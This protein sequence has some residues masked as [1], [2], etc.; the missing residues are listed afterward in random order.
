MFETAAISKKKEY[1]EVQQRKRGGSPFLTHIHHHL[2]L[3]LCHFSLTFWLCQGYGFDFNFIPHHSMMLTKPI[4][5][6]GL[7][8]LLFYTGN[9]ISISNGL[10]NEP[11]ALKC[12]WLLMCSAYMKKIQ[13]LEVFSTNFFQVYELNGL[14]F[15]C[16]WPKFF[17]ACVQQARPKQ[18]KPNQPNKLRTEPRY[19]VPFTQWRQK[20]SKLSNAKNPNVNCP[21]WADP[22][23]DIVVVAQP[24][25]P[26]MHSVTH[27][28]NQSR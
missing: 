20:M 13:K 14:A 27:R 21:S 26:P 4:Q 22:Q 6:S 7:C 1:I 9:K 8:V 5:G 19:T 15:P 28:T 3:S 10:F 16:Y 23:L 12:Y 2:E 11:P 17:F 24:T 25:A 18:A